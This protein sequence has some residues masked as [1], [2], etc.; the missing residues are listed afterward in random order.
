MKERQVV[1]TGLGTLCALG[2]NTQTFWESLK[3]GYCGI[4]D[5]EGFENLNLKTAARLSNYDPSQHF[6]KTALRNLDPFAQYLAIASREA[7]AD[8][9]LTLDPLR[10]A[11][12][13]ATA[14]GGQETQDGEY[15]RVYLK[16]GKRMQP[17]TVP[18]SMSSA[19]ASQISLELGLTGPCFT[20]STACSSSNHAIGL[21]YWMVRH[22]MAE[23][24]LTGGSEAPF[25][26][27]TSFPM[28]LGRGT[29]VMPSPT[30]LLSAGLT[31]SW[32]LGN[33]KT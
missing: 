14:S 16:G 30:L 4:R 6:D 5:L 10:T 25:A 11:V 24:A 32:H 17:L 3:N 18:R 31:P 7:V 23:A 28:K 12:I 15:R 27:W 21:A 13:S 29:C 1:V 33:H 19:G 20:L 8:S 9:G 22:G 26:T 2:E